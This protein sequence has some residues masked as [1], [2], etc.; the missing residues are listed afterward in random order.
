MTL[1]DPDTPSDNS[2]D[3]NERAPRPKVVGHLRSVRQ[4]VG[5]GNLGVLGIDGMLRIAR[6]DPQVGAFSVP[7]LESLEKTLYH[8]AA[9]YGFYGDKVLLRLSDELPH[10]DI[11]AV[12]H[13]G[14]YLIEGRPSE[15]LQLIGPRI[16]DDAILTSGARSIVKQTYPFLHKALK[17]GGNL[18]R[19]S[20]P[21]APPGYSFHGAGDFAMGHRG[22]GAAK[23]ERA[24][25]SKELTTIDAPVGKA[26]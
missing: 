11:A 8:N 23:A 24:L 17:T 18:S 25:Q 6:S 1:F 5:Y 7:E 2:P 26:A 3:Q 12:P 21:L 13:T 22:L 9:L 4:T 20:R 15:T 16:G 19:A 10:G 14:Q